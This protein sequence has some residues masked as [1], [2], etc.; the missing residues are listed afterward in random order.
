MRTLTA[1]FAPGS[2]PLP[3]G[4]RTLQVSPGR[5][6]EP[7]QT[8]HASFTFKN[9]GGGTATGFRVRFRLPEGLTY[10]VGTARVDDE[11]IDEQGGLTS[12][13]QSSGAKLGDVP[14]GGERRISLAYTV[15]STIENGTQIALQAAIASFEV[16]VIGSNVV[17][18][19]VRSRPMLQS[20]ATRLSLTPVREA[21]PGAELTLRAQ[22]HNS[23]QSSAHDV[24]VLLPVPP[25]TTYV[26]Q[27]ATVGGRV[28]E[29]LSD[30]EPFGLAT[31]T[32]VAPVLGPGA[33]LDAGY[34][35]RIDPTL[36]DNAQIT[37][38]GSVCTQELP[39]FALSP[40]TLK[41][42]S[43]PSFD[44]EETSLRV[45]AED[46]VVPGQRVRVVV[47]LRNVGTAR[48]RDV[49]V[50]LKLPEGL[51]YSAGS[52]AIDGAPA[53]DR[54]R[55]P[56]LF[57]L[58]DVEPGR[59]VEVALAG[60]VASPIALGT[61][62]PVEA[63][64]EWSKGNRAF[65]RTLTVRSA[66]AFPAA[67]NRIEREGPRR[68]A[69]GDVAV[70]SVHVE[71]MGADVATDVRLQLDADAGFEPLKVSGADGEIVVDDNG[72][73][74]LDALEPNTP[75]TFRVETR[76]APT[77]DDQTQL[78]VRATLKT[79]KL[80]EVDLGS[81]QHTIGSRPRFSA[82]T[83]KLVAEAG[84]VLRPN[85]TA[86]CR[87]T[88]HNEG[89]DRGKDVRVRLQLPE[90][91][92]L[93]SV[94]GGA[95]DAESV[96]FGEVPAQETREAT[97]HLRLLGIAGADEVL[98]V[99]AR[100]SGSNVVPLSLEP[101]QLA[102]H[103]EPAF[104][105]GAT[106]T[107]QPVEAVDAGEEV[108]YT[109]ALRNTGDGVAHRI[110]AR[111]DAPTNSVYAPGST[112]VNGVPLLDNAGTSPLLAPGGLTLGEVGSGVEMIARLAVI[113]NTPLPPGTAIDTRARITWDDAPEMVVRAE[114]LRV[115]SAHA[116]PI[117]DPA[118]PF[119]VLDAAAAP[120]RANGRPRAL[121]PGELD[122]EYIEL[123]AGSAST[124]AFGPTTVDALPP[125]TGAWSDNERS[126]DEAASATGTH[127]D[128]TARL[129][130]GEPQ[131]QSSR[132][133]QLT[134]RLTGDRLEWITRYLGE[135]GGT[136]LIAH[137]TMIRALF[138]DTAHDPSTNAALQRYAAVLNELVDRLFVKMRLPNVE[139]VQGDLET[140]KARA[141]FTALLEALR[142]RTAPERDDGSGLRLTA[143]IDPA[144][145]EA[146]AGELPRAPIAT[147]APW[148]LAAMLM[149][150]LLHREGETVADFT[151]YRDA[152][153]LA[154]A[155]FAT[156]P[157]AD[158]ECALY[159]P[160]GAELERERD[161]IV[162]ELSSQRNVPA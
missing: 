26:A 16:P 94:D 116:L 100:V 120:S 88:V 137:L 115:R 49:R 122:V 146:A 66:P 80:G 35:V 152:L 134:L 156:L 110:N 96:V 28:R 141:S 147:A 158:F 99:G 97:I 157:P 92:R 43:K 53:V 63:R 149:G 151:R 62:L 145:L 71:N 57:Q 114:P 150:N 74:R 29:G 27:S 15:A 139:V 140:D 34:R 162:R 54:G 21:V 123:P 144:A 117:V 64:V 159:Q 33:T 38:Q 24:M 47:H 83:S 107:S 31:P 112:T 119:S 89:T 154:L 113:V 32:I 36:D 105:E 106:L 161:R 95:R 73:V 84:D 68:L 17:R 129:S 142:A 67:F 46:E 155:S 9:L 86:A 82:S 45:E 87:L 56:G 81:A 143:L 40:V 130:K 59:S 75:R 6:I 25:N 37:A 76:V 78:R 4:L 39:E 153:A 2:A 118:L 111:I 79:A 132:T 65:A 126:D 102:T 55:E 50:R 125:S 77:V 44:G 48:A 42:P 101:I 124:T 30:A 7:G 20:T 61:E 11:E 19:V 10:L 13:L 138:P 5:V 135:A 41:I 121:G 98:E 160:A 22:I 3:E 148:A 90:E 12:L 1:V 60:V 109:L 58:G 18:L 127:H 85:R 133:I 93:E 8:I 23:G 70:F 108:L 104:D 103:A 51:A 72:G 52:R 131:P 14:A 136:R 91:L 128:A 69:P